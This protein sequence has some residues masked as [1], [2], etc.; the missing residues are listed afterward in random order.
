MTG[1]ST[2]R[3]QSS[4]AIVSTMLFMAV[5]F[6]GCTQEF[7]KADEDKLFPEEMQVREQFYATTITVQGRV[8]DR[9]GDPV[10]G[11]KVILD[12]VAE[13]APLDPEVITDQNGSWEFSGL[14]RHNRLIVVSA[15]G[16]RDE[17]RPVMLFR[18]F[19]ELSVTM[20]PVI[21]SRSSN[22][23]VRFLFGGDVSFGRRYMD[24]YE[25]TPFNKIPADHPEGIIKASDPVPG[26]MD[27]GHFIQPEFVR[28]DFPVVNFECPV[29]DN[30]ATPHT[31][32]PYVFFSLPET[33]EALR[34][35]GVSYLSMGNNHIY[36]YLEQG[37]LD[38]IANVKDQ[39]FDYTGF[40]INSTEAFKPFRT[41]LK[42]HSYSF[43][44]MSS[45]SGSQYSVDFTAYEDKGGSADLRDSAAVTAA[46]EKERDAEHIVIAQLHTGREYTK[47][48]TDYAI[49]RFRLAIDAG[50][51][52]IIS[53]HPHV[54]Q[55]FSLYNGVLVANSLG[56]LMFDQAILE[57]MPSLMARIDMA[58]EEVR[59]AWGIPI[60]IEDFRPR[61]FGGDMSDQMLRRLGEDSVQQQA[62]LFPYNGVGYVPLSEGEYVTLRRSMDIPI[63]IS[64]KGTALV[65]L[66][67]FARADESAGIIS[68]DSG[69]IRVQLGRDL[70]LN[71]DFEDWDVDDDDME[72]SRWD[73]TSGSRYPCMHNPHRGT[74]AGCSVRDETNISDTVIAYRNRTRILGTPTNEPNKDL[75]LLVYARGVNAGGITVVTRYYASVDDA[76]FGEEEPI[77]IAPGSYDW[78]GL[79]S[80]LSMPTDSP[81]ATNCFTQCPRAVRV[82]LRHGPPRHGEGLASFDDVALI[83]WNPEQTVG[84]GFAVPTP[85]PIDFVKVYGTPGAHTLT[86][87]FVSHKPAASR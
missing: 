5:V 50:A 49:N 46:I 76:E 69:V 1:T 30:P 73:V 82:F 83:N 27:V 35:M 72:V 42:D 44:S 32:K 54:A 75:S 25:S 55:G 53:H 52:L 37:L 9:N 18:P 24:P 26:A 79:W 41:T 34:W 36:D 2:A 80:D 86:V 7:P 56:N 62:M 61:L 23:V 85:H 84:S 71:G 4:R 60:Y 8:V 14:S 74:L 15:P 87:T 78:T 58:G 64:D 48:P 40:G 10:A 33:L 39:G 68:G 3:T 51:H 20:E 67:N 19:T 81:R 29:L 66:R 12:D 65:D 59:G 45:V 11:A 28:A 16:F 77:I 38:T 43:L 13:D 57:T 22:D 31:T 21:L 17:I 70:M 47:N 63:V 6:F